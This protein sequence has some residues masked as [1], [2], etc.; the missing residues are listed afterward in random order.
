MIAANDD[1]GPL[2]KMECPFSIFD[3][4]GAE[5]F[6]CGAAI[7]KFNKRTKE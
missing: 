5:T 2:R 3:K 4:P 6:P 7:R 1:Q